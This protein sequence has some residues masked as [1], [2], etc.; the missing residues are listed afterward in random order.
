MLVF[1]IFCAG[2]PVLIYAWLCI[3]DVKRSLCQNLMVLTMLISNIGYLSLVL[4]RNLEEALL[5]LKIAYVGG[6]FLTL[7]YF[8]TVCEVCHVVLRKRW[9]VLLCF[10]QAVIYGLVCT[11]G[12]NTW[13]YREV[14][15]EIVRGIGHLNK[16]YGPTHWL[17]PASMYAL[18][19]ASISVALFAGARKNTVNYKEI[20]SMLISAIL[21]VL[22][23]VVYRGFDTEFQIMP[24][25]YIILML[26]AL[27]PIYHSNLYTVDENQDIIHEQLGKVAF[28]AFNNKMEFM[29]ANEAAVAIFEELK[30]FK[31]G[32]RIGN[33]SNELKGLLEEVEQFRNSRKNKSGHNH[34][35]KTKHPINGLIYDAEIHTLENFRGKCAGYALAIRN[36]TEHYQMLD[37]TERYNEE[38]MDEVD[39]KTERIRT[40][41][42]K[43]ILG[44]AQMVESRD[45]STGGHVK[46]TSDVIRIFAGK[47][48]EQN[49]G[50]DQHFLSLVIRSAPM[51]DLGK[52]GVDDAVLRKQGRFTEEEYE[53]MRQHS[54]IG[55]EMVCDILT[56]VEE[57]DFVRVAYNVAKYHHEKVNGHGYP[58]GL[59]GEDIPVEA[60][61]MALA[62]VFDALVSKRCYKEAYSYDEAFE[63]IKLD[64]GAHFDRELALVFL[65]CRQELENYYNRDMLHQGAC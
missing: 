1:F 56:G 30:D 49:M 65:Q 40:I 60:R 35:V 16:V 31:V 43:T 57:D 23:Y 24:V 27:V 7:L 25:S 41:Q 21:A 34:E 14:E 38:L 20:R 18:L 48:L 54:E 37:L 28:L 4:S 19:M 51:H 46:R 50:F 33:P 22:C 64:A 17:Y 13:Y 52:I 32:R 55:G 2:I 5:S 47:L 53:K 61:I 10:V 11:M 58:C 59:K 8:F 42:E 36:E 63:I 12:Y 3:T 44:M 62:D 39:R 26:G 15:F 29:G 9:K 45:L 6:T